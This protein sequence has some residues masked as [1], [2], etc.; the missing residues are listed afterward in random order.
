ML[1]IGLCQRG[2]LRIIEKPL[3]N[4]LASVD[5]W[6]LEFFFEI[7]CYI[8]VVDEPF[9]LSLRINALALKFVQNST[10]F[11]ND[12][13]PKKRQTQSHAHT[14][15]CHLQQ[16]RSLEDRAN[17]VAVVHVVLRAPRADVASKTLT[18]PIHTHQVQLVACPDTCDKII[19]NK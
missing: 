17:V 13:F 12:A 8:S 2:P 18:V 9:K 3:V 1:T 4:T 19:D 11:Y 10:F 16:V 15:N 14:F 6:T 5:F 7:L